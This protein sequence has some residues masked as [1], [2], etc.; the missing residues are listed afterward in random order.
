MQIAVILAVLSTTTITASDHR[1]EE[2][3]SSGPPASRLPAFDD[4]RFMLDEN[5]LAVDGQ[6]VDAPL[7]ERLVRI[8][9]LPDRTTGRDWG[10]PYLEAAVRDLARQRPDAVFTVG[11]MVQGYTR[12]EQRYEREVDE[13]QHAI[14]PIADR[15]YPTAGNHDVISGHRDPEDTRFVDRYRARFGPLHYSVR[16]GGATMIILF[17]DEGMSSGRMRFSE[18]QRNWLEQTLESAEPGPRVLLMHRPLWRYDTIDWWERVQPMLAKHEVDAVIAGHFHSLQKD[19]TRDGVEYHILGTCGGMIDQHPLAGQLQ[20][21]TLL[22]MDPGRPRGERFQLHH[23]VA[24][25]TLPDDF[26]TT[27]DQN[28]VLELKTNPRVVQVMDAI[29]DTA[30]GRWETPVRFDLVNPIDRPVDFS[31]APSGGPGDWVVDDRTTWRSLTDRDTYNPNTMHGQGRSPISVSGSARLDP[32]ESAT[33]DTVVSCYARAGGGPGR[34]PQL[35]VTA[36]FE[37]EQGR[38]VPVVIRRRLAIE[39]DPVRLVRGG[40]PI[41]LPICAWTFSV[42]DNVEPDPECLLTLL[43]DGRLR[44]EIAVEGDQLVGPGSDG[45]PRSERMRNPMADAIRIDIACPESGERTVYWEP[46]GGPAELTDPAS[47][48]ATTL[49]EVALLE[50]ETG[51][52]ARLTLPGSVTLPVAIGIGVS[53]NDL[54]YH[55]QWRTLTPPGRMQELEGEP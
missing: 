2:P 55:T 1:P 12:D 28:R 54:T 26:I 9:I 33:L 18:D 34:P 35:D 13:Y 11:D 37:D 36:S 23:Q 51:W 4:G 6:Q 44:I 15:F 32:G 42:Y 19:E 47:D 39:R 20:H 3:A 43:E 40:P 14:G 17:S 7:P 31:I 5:D 30:R 49:D 48:V 29:P 27:R 46:L 25:T 16:I 24:G 21:V 10:M 45:R 52:R 53:D 38:R 22:Q 8:A 41:T 50:T